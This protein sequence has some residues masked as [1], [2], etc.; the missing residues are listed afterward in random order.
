M[1]R[2]LLAD[3]TIAALAKTLDG[4]AARHR[5]IA[6][7]IANADT[8][9][10]QRSDVSFESDLEAALKQA[11]AHPRTALDRIRSVRVRTVRDRSAPL[12]ADGNTV[13]I[14]REMASLAQNTM[15]FEAAAHALAT[16]LKMLRA[17]LSEGRK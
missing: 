7:N 3:A 12:R 13:D 8:P 17:A 16:K 5:A 15:R 2:D 10:F 4:A 14:E 9:G 6:E 1:S 11:P